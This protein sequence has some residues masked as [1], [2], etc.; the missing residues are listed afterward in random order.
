MQTDRCDTSEQKYHAHGNR[1]ETEI[2]T[3]LKSPNYIN[4]NITISQHNI[5]SGLIKATCIG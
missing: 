2:K 3:T 4:M 5:I 1:Y